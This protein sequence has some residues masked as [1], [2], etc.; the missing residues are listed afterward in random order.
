MCKDRWHRRVCQFDLLSGQ[1]MG[2]R[3]DGCGLACRNSVM[4]SV[5]MSHCVRA[6]GTRSGVPAFCMRRLG[7]RNVS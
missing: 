6:T 4:G 5:W 7:V 1:D 3:L 2:A